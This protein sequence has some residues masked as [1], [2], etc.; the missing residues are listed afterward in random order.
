MLTSGI[1]HPPSSAPSYRSIF[2]FNP[3]CLSPSHPH[4]F[5]ANKISL[6]I[7]SLGGALRV[8]GFCNFAW[9]AISCASSVCFRCIHCLSCGRVHHISFQLY[10]R[11]QSSHHFCS[12]ACISVSFTRASRRIPP[13]TCATTTRYES[14]LQN[15]E[16]PRTCILMITNPC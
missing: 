15:H 13:S 10:F 16:S 5:K 2:R 9:C 8:F 1:C 4:R 11:P 3:D 7:E 12:Q 14:E 6:I